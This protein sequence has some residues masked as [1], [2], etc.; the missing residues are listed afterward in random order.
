MTTGAESGVRI[1]MEACQGRSTP[2]G[3]PCGRTAGAE[4]TDRAVRGCGIAWPTRPG[5]TSPGDPASGPFSDRVGPARQ[6]G[7]CRVGRECLERQGCR[8]C[9]GWECQRQRWF[10]E[11]GCVASDQAGQAC[12]ADPHIGSSSACRSG[13]RN[14][15][16]V[17]RRDR[18]RKGPVRSSFGSPVPGTC[19]NRTIGH[20]RSTAGKPGAFA[21]DPVIGKPLPE[22]F[23]TYMLDCHCNETSCG[24]LQGF[25][26]APAMPPWPPSLLRSRSW[27]VAPYS[28]SSSPVSRTYADPAIPVGIACSA[29]WWMLRRPCEPQ[30]VL[31]V[32]ASA[33]GRPGR[34]NAW[35]F[36]AAFSSR[37]HSKPQRLHR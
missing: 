14:R 21:P 13:Q 34:P 27:P 9:L 33:D 37:S 35:R 11:P 8:V 23:G 1:G 24:R 17:A 4:G 6:F 7:I 18:L 10:R 12:L 3:I 31:R 16:G 20:R 26:T 29:V 32:S 5:P 28:G 22:V 36:R 25:G 15:M 30:S 2:A 19:K